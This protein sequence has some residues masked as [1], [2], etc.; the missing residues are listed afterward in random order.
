MVAK[1]KLEE[2]IAAIRV[3]ARSKM[4]EATGVAVVI[5]AG[6]II[7][8]D[9]EVAPFAGGLKGVMFKGTTHALFL[10]DLLHRA[11]KNTRREP[12]AAA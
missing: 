11:K 9:E 7:E 2:N 4:N 3:D 5:P 8:L 6:E 1:I 12:I 10:D